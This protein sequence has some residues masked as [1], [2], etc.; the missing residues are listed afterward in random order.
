V[1]L[2]RVITLKDF[3]IYFDS[4]LTFTLH[5]RFCN[6]SLKKQL[7]FAFYLKKKK[8]VNMGRNVINFLLKRWCY[9]SLFYKRIIF[10]ESNK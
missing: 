7:Y 8:N 4:D 10:C 2:Q 6:I 9:V 3:S 5:E 1:A